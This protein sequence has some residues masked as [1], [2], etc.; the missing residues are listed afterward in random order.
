[1]PTHACEKMISNEE[2]SVL[3]AISWGSGRQKDEKKKD[4]NNN[5]DEKEKEDP[6]VH[7]DAIMIQFRFLHQLCKHIQESCQIL[8][9][10]STSQTVF[11]KEPKLNP[12]SLINHG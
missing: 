7:H 12:H 6:N 1:M 3:R 11:I 4:N 9:G 10:S 2:Y 8:I 5:N